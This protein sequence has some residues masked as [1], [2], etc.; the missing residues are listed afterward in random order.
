M[1]LFFIF[2]LNNV[3][4]VFVSTLTCMAKLKNLSYFVVFFWKMLY[5]WYW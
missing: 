4:V 3:R 5:I 1:E 2:N